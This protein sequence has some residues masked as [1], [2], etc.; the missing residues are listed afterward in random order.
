M[1]VRVCGH[2]CACVFEHISNYNTV[3]VLLVELPLSVVQRTHLS[4]LEPARDAVEVE[5]MV[6]H[7]PGHCA[8]LTGG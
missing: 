4:G 6:A 7:T 5:G 8:L 1:C 2:V 3:V